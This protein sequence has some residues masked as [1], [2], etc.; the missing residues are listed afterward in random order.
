MAGALAQVRSYERMARDGEV[1]QCWAGLK[2]DLQV[3]FGIFRQVGSYE[4][5]AR[6]LGLSEAGFAGFF[7]IFGMAGAM[8][9]QVRSYERMTSVVRQIT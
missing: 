3:F 7:G 1:C 2:Q 4:S 8:L 6:V 9:A 5:T